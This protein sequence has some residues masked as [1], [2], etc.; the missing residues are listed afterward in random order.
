MSEFDYNAA[1]ELFPARRRVPKRQPIGYRRF[2]QAAQAIRFAVEEVAPELL[3]GACLEVDERRYGSDD[4]RR[5]Y[6][7]SN[8]P[9]ARRA[10]GR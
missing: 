1:A 10:S 8:Y 3:V 5:L 6:E 9:L 4:I 2:A 7:S